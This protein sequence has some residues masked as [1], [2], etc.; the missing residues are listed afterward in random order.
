MMGY[1]CSAST[2][3][4][5]FTM[6]FVFCV[7]INLILRDRVGSS[8]NS[9]LFVILNYIHISADSRARPAM[10]TSNECPMRQRDRAAWWASRGFCE[11]SKFGPLLHVERLG[12][13]MSR[14]A[15][16]LTLAARMPHTNTRPVKTV[17]R[18]AP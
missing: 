2:G 6:S 15:N 11:G 18:D 14:C 10:K 9:T 5:A 16:M 8:V 4:V 12:S 17:I 3:A 1:P 7:N 13:Y